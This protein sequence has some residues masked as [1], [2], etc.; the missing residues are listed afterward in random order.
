MNFLYVCIHFLRLSF[1]S[2]DHLL[3]N[4]SHLQRQSKKCKKWRWF[5]DCHMKR[6]FTKSIRLNDC[7]VFKKCRYQIKV[8]WW[9]LGAFNI[10][11]D[12][13]Q[14]IDWHFKQC[15]VCNLLA[16]QQISSMN[17]TQSTH[18]VNGCFSFHDFVFLL[19]SFGL[20]SKNVFIRRFEQK[21]H[22]IEEMKKSNQNNTR[23]HKIIWT[24]VDFSSYYYFYAQ[25]EM[26]G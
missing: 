24:C 9:N 2:S 3:I 1:C 17:V 6:Q 26:L 13:T 23:T 16:K 11:N 22:K 25:N 15:R 18:D 4:L 5:D 14:Q 8:G 19:V 10:L 21:T 12:F 7:S 20:Q